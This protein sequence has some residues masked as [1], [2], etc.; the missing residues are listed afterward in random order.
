MVKLQ[1]SSRTKSM[2]KLQYVG[3][4]KNCFGILF[5]VSNR[6]YDQIQKIAC[7]M[8]RF[9]IDGGATCNG[10]AIQPN[11]PMVKSAT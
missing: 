5:Q 10:M 3:K 1:F 6:S 9:R 4:P 2:R 8:R 7:Y 11:S